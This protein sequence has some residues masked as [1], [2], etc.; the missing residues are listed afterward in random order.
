VCT[1]K[2]CQLDRIWKTVEGEHAPFWVTI[3]FYTRA[4]GQ[5]FIPPTIVHQ[6]SEWTSDM[7]MNL[8]DN[9]IVHSTPSGYMDRDGFTKTCKNFVR[10]SGSSKTNPQFNFFDGHDSHWAPDALD[11]LAEN[12]TRAFFLKAGDSTKDQPND[13]GPNCC[14][15]AF[16][17]KLYPL[18]CRLFDKTGIHPLK[19]PSVMNA[20]DILGATC[21]YDDIEGE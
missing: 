9:W 1:Y 14:L 4:D 3:L 19:A 6:G 18:L 20:S 21:T 15:R 5:V 16:V 12:G 13:N 11:T 7:G 2:W 8:P 10:L 17:L